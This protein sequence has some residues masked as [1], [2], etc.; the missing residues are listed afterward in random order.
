MPLY[1]VS[2]TVFL[3]GTDECLAVFDDEMEVAAWL[4]FRK[5]SRDQVEVV[6]DASPMS[7]FTAWE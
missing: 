1:P 3:R 2:Y 7:S 6:S 4:A 5:L